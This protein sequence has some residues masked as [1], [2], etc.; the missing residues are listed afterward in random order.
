MEH[1]DWIRCILAYTL[2]F[3]IDVGM[4]IAF[5]FPLNDAGVNETIAVGYM[6]LRAVRER[7]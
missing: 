5:D 1:R 6:V 3:F 7:S 2:I 4:K